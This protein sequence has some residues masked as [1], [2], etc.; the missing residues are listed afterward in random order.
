[1]W[2]VLNCLWTWKKKQDYFSKGLFRYI[3]I[4]NQQKIHKNQMLEDLSFEMGPLPRLF[5]SPHS[6]PEFRVSSFTV[7]TRDTHTHVR[8]AQEPVSPAS[9]YPFVW[10]G[11][12]VPTGNFFYYSHCYF[13][14]FIFCSVMWKHPRGWWSWRWVRKKK[15]RNGCWA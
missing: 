11:V 3:P 9:F 4:L 5:S 2:K 7:N 12:G 10:V 8:R 14:I 6:S 13:F 15:K 1:M